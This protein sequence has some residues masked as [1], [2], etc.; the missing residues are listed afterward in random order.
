MSNRLSN[1]FCERYTSRAVQNRTYF[2]KNILVIDVKAS[3]CYDEI[4][5]K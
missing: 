2:T 3:W 4:T 1:R 5:T